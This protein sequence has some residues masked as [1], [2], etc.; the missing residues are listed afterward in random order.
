MRLRIIRSA[1]KLATVCLLLVVASASVH[2]VQPRKKKEKPKIA[3]MAIASVDQKAMTITVESRNSTANVSKTYK[4]TPQTKIMVSGHDG[5][6]GDLKPGLQI[7]FSAGANAD[8][9][10]ELSASPAP[11]DPN[12]R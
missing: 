4:F 3:Y 12:E 6:V 10:Q 9:A 5:A 11:A 1:K 2:A 7:R 8:V